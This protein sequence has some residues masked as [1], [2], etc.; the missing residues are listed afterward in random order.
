[1]YAFL[2]TRL[3][4]WRKGR[5]GREPLHV[6]VS[7]PVEFLHLN[8]GSVCG[9]FFSWE[10]MLAAL[11]SMLPKEGLLLSYRIYTSPEDKI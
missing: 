9:C 7:A 11:R 6:P 4:R 1:M 10:A 5:R 2:G 3:P 8:A